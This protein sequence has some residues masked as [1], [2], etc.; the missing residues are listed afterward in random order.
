MTPPHPGR[1]LDPFMHSRTWT[2][3]AWSA[4][5]WPCLLL[6]AAAAGDES[7]TLLR[8][9]LRDG[10]S[11]IS[12]GEPAKVGE[13]VVFSM[14]TDPTPNPPLHLVNLP[15]E[16][17]DWERTDRYANAARQSHYLNTR[18][19]LDYTELSNQLAQTLTDVASMTDAAQRLATVERARQAL[20]AWPAAHYNYRSAEV[21][22][23]LGLLDEAI[24][25]LRAARGASRFDI[26]LSAF[27]EPPPAIDEPILPPPT[28]LESIQQVLIAARAVD[29]SV[30]RMS[31]LS[32]ALA[33]IDGHKEGLPS[34]W[35]SSTREEV[36]TALRAE[37]K[38]DADYRA[39]T[40]STIAIVNRRAQAADVRGV[41]RLLN[42]VQL[43]DRELGGQRPEAVAA[44][45]ATIEAKLDATRRLRL[46]R[47]RWEL[48]LPVLVE[49]GA[50]IRAPIALFIQMKPSLEDIK[51]L[52]GSSPASLRLL[53]DGAARLTTLLRAIDPPDELSAAHALMGS[54]AQLAVSAV[55]VRREAVLA[56]DMDRAWNA[57]SAAAGAL[58]LGTRARAEILQ[59]LRPPRLQ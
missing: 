31:L 6:T 10:T 23:M 58:M 43:R 51:A 38:I 5:L 41:E 37:R 14:P 45:V 40:D 2:A 52:A 22:Q 56:N 4:V 21:R 18:A 59:L 39:L 17:V 28:L 47:D 27:S 9:F 32:A 44:L 36:E 1:T 53:S 7:A 24:A 50:A 16:R 8:V 19:E 49:Y 3:V 35:V 30:E 11:L 12:Y 34:T 29:S 46:A 26:S 57:S 48:R 25:D 20:S 13:R 15:A 42:R 33:A 55:T 54:A